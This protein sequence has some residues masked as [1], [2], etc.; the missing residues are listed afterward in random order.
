VLSRNGPA[1]LTIA[2][3]GSLILIGL[4]NGGFSAN[5]WGWTAI[6]FGTAALVVLTLSNGTAPALSVA[7]F[8]ALVG[9]VVWTA[10]S[11]A[12]SSDITS[13]VRDVQRDL[14][15]VTAAGAALTVGSR[16]VALRSA[17]LFASSTLAVYSVATHLAPDVFGFFSQVTMPGRLYYP[18]GYWNAQG[19]LGSLAIIL[20]ADA[21]ANS[22]P[23]LARTLAAA[24]LPW[25]AVDVLLTL[26]RGAELSLLFGLVMWLVLDPRRVR[27]SAFLL[28]LSAPA[29]VAAW[30]ANRIASLYGRL[31]APASAADGH[32]LV[33]ELVVLSMMTVAVV[34]LA[35]NH[36]PDWSFPR[37]TRRLYFLFLAIVL[38]SAL[39]VAVA[40]YGDPV[41]WPASAYRTFTAKPKGP[42]A[43]SRLTTFSLNHRNLLWSVAIDESESNVLIGSG[44]GTFGTHWF[45]ERTVPIDT[46]SAHSL[47]LETLAESGIVGLVL[48][49]LVSLIPLIGAARCRE[50]AHVPAMAGAYGA[51]LLHTGV[52]WDWLVPGM[53]IPA[54]W[55]G[56]AI[57]ASE[58]GA[59]TVALRGATRWCIGALLG[60]VTVLGALG[61]VGNI[62]LSQSYE[63][64]NIGQYGRAIQEAHDAADW[65][66]WSFLPWMEIG[67]ANQ[68][69]GDQTAALAAYRTAARRDPVRW[70]PWASLAALS[71]GT[72]R[73]HALREASRLNP[74]GSQIL[75]LCKQPRTPGCPRGR[76]TP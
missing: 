51:C 47:Y 22:K 38:M 7:T 43:P 26:S 50:I 13:G 72:Y 31:Y 28:C 8:A 12:W 76:R 49:A 55:L 36:A 52:D 21:A 32:R 60:A 67:S 63:A 14:V 3:A 40:S 64:A 25:P 5:A 46:T 69:L 75:A 74:L 59:R 65:Q 18:L 62:R 16:A 10:V 53:T 73:T 29:V 57:L 68:A 42:I 23:P 20:L 70:E 34:W 37:W 2:A 66:P 61:L 54:I 27:A 44:A 58:Q 35:V 48:V 11:L 9:F 45:R 1:P 39:G 30:R 19:M 4:V 6:G 17:V 56:Y 71:T 41:H 15:Y 24:A 33:L